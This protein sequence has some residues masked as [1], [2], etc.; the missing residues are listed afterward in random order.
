MIKAFISHSSKQ[1]PFVLELVERLGRNFCKLDCFDFQPAYKTLDEIYKAIDSAT[2][3]VL[4]LSKDSLN[5]TW[6]EEEIRYARE[7]LQSNDM[8]RF[9]PYLIDESIS[10]E[11]CPEWMTKDESFNL[12]QFK[13]PYILARDIEQ[14][15]RHIIWSQ[16]SKLKLRE[17]IM[18]GRNTDIAKFEDKFQSINGMNLKALV[19]SGRDGVGKETFARQCMNKVGFDLE[20]V[21]Y[22]ISFN[23]KENIENFIVY[24]NM[25]L[26]K[27]DGESLKQILL[28]DPK[29]KS[30]EAVLMLNELYETQTVVFIRD[31]LACILPTRELSEWMIDILDDKDLNNQLGMFIMTHKIPSTFIESEHPQVAHI[32]LEPLD[33]KDRRK[34][35]INCIRSYGL[36]GVTQ[37]DVDFFVDKLLQSPSQ[38]IQVA[39]SLSNGVP[40][41]LVKRDINNLVEQGDIKIKPVLDRFSE[42]EQRY[43]LIIM[44]RMDFISYELLEAIFSTRIVETMETIYEMMEYGIVTSFGPSS[45][46]F[47]LDHYVS[48]Y[49]RRCHL[50]LPSDW[51]ISVTEVLE[52]KI[53]QSNSITEDTSLYLYDLKRKLISGGRGI[54]EFLFPS[55]VV[56]SVI[57]VY[58]ERN[59]PLVIDVCDKVLNGV[60]PYYEDVIRELR[61][62]LC[63]ALCRLQN[64]R[65]F[66][67][68]KNLSGADY[69]FL[70][71]FYLRNGLKY[72]DAEKYYRQALQQSRNLQRA[73]REL[74]TTLLAQNK[75]KDALEMAKENYEKDPDNSYQIHGYFRCLVRKHGM[76]LQ[77]RE[78]LKQ[79]MDAMSVNYSDK[80][81][82]LLE[83]MNIEYQ[84]Y[85]LHNSPSA[86]IDIFDKAINLYPKSV[87]IERAA[88]N[89]KKNQEM[90]TA[91]KIFR[92][93]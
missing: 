63:L 19:I 24:L 32:Q 4:L 37:Q 1:K 26:R 56:S 2:V 66:E 34:L 35:F 13:S 68:V 44:S 74:V 15:F 21:P 87:N 41:H 51:E 84:A 31:N 10:I 46:F 92:E 73:K 89:Y 90:V 88:Y 18:V 67:E 3:F 64:A 52:S 78:V 30:H 72:S 8:D 57:D 49:I 43:L 93:E 65:F 82:E 39:E 17:T 80:H 83:A 59:Y 53:T 61:Y 79:L 77:D 76:T 9:W 55:V 12:K 48:D 91:D 86:M 11:D 40:M 62:W 75:Y 81:E 70:R 27:H 36:Q 45:Q 60:H 23:P 29:E 47:R 33:K 22:R 85:V 16:N 50:V 58:N 5:S 38:I 25:I 6:V 14:K 42:D 69:F 28:L 71:G 20:T 7:K 54:G